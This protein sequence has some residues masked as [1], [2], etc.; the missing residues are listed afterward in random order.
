MKKD[1]L[2]TLNQWHLLYKYLH[3]E[4]SSFLYQWTH[5]FK[6]IKEEDITN[7]DTKALLEDYKKEEK[8]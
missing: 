8:L 1:I 6:K 7:K 4:S 5:C 3:H 2:D